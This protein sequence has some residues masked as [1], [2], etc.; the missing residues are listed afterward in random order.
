MSTENAHVCQIVL[1]VCR[2]HE[3][4]QHSD[5]TFL[6]NGQSVRAHRC[7]LAVRSEYFAEMLENKWADRD[8]VTINHKMVRA[9]STGGIRTLTPTAPSGLQIFMCHP[10]VSS[11]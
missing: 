7:V 11:C 5:I 4:G 1:S 6:V 2:I 9:R 3:R 10:N 8:S